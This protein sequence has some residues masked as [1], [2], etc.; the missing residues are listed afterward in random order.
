MN[1]STHCICL[2]SH[3]SGGDVLNNVLHQGQVSILRS[4]LPTHKTLAPQSYVL[5]ILFSILL[6]P[7]QQRNKLKIVFLV[8]LESG[9]GY[10]VSVFVVSI[11]MSLCP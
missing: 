2:K 8:L 6:T 1:T 4:I 7:F 3:M 11:V 10:T 5:H 9:F